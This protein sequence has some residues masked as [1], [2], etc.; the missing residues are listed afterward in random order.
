MVN[1]HSH[2][3]PLSEGE[4]YH[5]QIVGLRVRTTAGEIVGTVI[6]IISGKSNDNYIVDS[7]ITQNTAS[8]ASAVARLLDGEKMAAMCR[9]FG[10]SRAVI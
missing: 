6:D 3:S 1:D 7:T 2:D 9:E 4:Y 5:H 8:S 10:W